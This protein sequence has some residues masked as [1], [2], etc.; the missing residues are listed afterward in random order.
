MFK[1]SCDNC[2]KAIKSDAD[3]ISVDM[4]FKDSEKFFNHHDFCISCIKFLP[5]FLKKVMQK[6]AKKK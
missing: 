2:K 5:S 3:F 6:K 4:Q 1:R